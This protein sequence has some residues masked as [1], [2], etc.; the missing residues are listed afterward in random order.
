MSSKYVLSKEQNDLL[1]K[2][3]YDKG[4]LFG[5][6][7]IFQYVKANYPDMKLSRRQVM[8]WLRKQETHQLYWP[9][10]VTKD[11]R[12]TDLKEPHSQIAIDLVD[13]SL[14][15]Y[16]G[17]HWILTAVDLFSKFAY[18]VP[19]KNKED[20][21]VATAMK[22]LLKNEIHHVDSIRSDNG[23]E[24][25]SKKFQDLL[26]DY[27]VTQVLSKPG[28]PQ[29]NGGIERFNKTLKRYLLMTLTVKNSYDWVSAVSDMV[30]LYNETVNDVTKKTPDDLNEEVEK[31]ELSQVRDNIKK[32]VESGN[33]K[34]GQLFEVGD[35][36]RRKLAP[37]ERTNSQNWSTD[38]F[39][40][41]KIEK[42]KKLSLSSFAYYI[43]DS[44]GKY[45]VKFYNNDLLKIPD[46]QNVIDKPVKQ[47]VSKLIKPVIRNGEPSYQ[48]R[49]K[50][51]K[52]KDDT[53]EPRKNLIED[54]PK[55]VKAFEKDHNVHWY[56]KSVTYDE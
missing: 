34:A 2:L 10:K 13:M 5:R 37:D 41:Y 46:I 12:H 27:G 33:D 3:Y 22:Y 39:E 30:S 52:P 16:N 25:I 50:Y 28:K 40:V 48:V 42:P 20:S 51:L 49:W 21:T 36:V 26:E 24:F 4:L 54:V 6:D 32:S 8:E 38:L 55:I 56:N 29:S 17:F 35:K 43:K 18:A 9:S 31:S 53:I 45:T 11:I 1:Y 23:S 7:R 15:A 44:R 47:I 14:R 19:M